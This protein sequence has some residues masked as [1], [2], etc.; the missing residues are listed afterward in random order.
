MTNSMDAIKVRYSGSKELISIRDFFKKG[1]EELTS[2]EQNIQHALRE[3]YKLND[4]NP[5][6]YTDLPTHDPK[7][8]LVMNC[9][10]AHYLSKCSAYYTTG[11]NE[12]CFISKIGDLIA[13][14]AHELKHAEQH[15]DPEIQQICNGSDNRK[16]QEDMLMREAEAFF[17]GAYAYAQ[18]GQNREETPVGFQYYLDVQKKCVRPDGTHD[19]AKMKQEFMTLMVI[20][21]AE[22]QPP[23]PIQREMRYPVTDKDVGLQH[24]PK[25]YKLDD[26]FLT[27][28]KR[29]PRE[30]KTDVGKIRQCI[31]N[32][33]Q[34]LV[35]PI[36]KKIVA[37]GRT[38]S[39]ILS[40]F[41]D[42]S[43]IGYD[44]QMVVHELLQLKGNDL[45]RPLFDKDVIT[46]VLCNSIEKGKQDF[47][48]DLKL[49]QSE[50]DP[51][52]FATASNKYFSFTSEDFDGGRKLLR[53]LGPCSLEQK[54]EMVPF[55]VGFKGNNNAPLIESRALVEYL[56]DLCARKQD[57]KDVETLF[58]SLKDKQGRLPVAHEDFVFGW[59]D[60]SKEGD[61]IIL[62]KIVS[63]LNSSACIPS[64]YEKNKEYYLKILP[65]LIS[66]K[67]KDGKA[68]I[69]Q[70]DIANFPQDNPLASAIKAYKKP[71]GKQK[72]Q[73]FIAS[74]QKT[75]LGNSSTRHVP[76]G[77]N[78]PRS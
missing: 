73:E 21:L 50:I 65:V 13:T 48:D 30:A 64:I 15:A 60:P 34:D 38:K 22:H 6:L 59:N 69:S 57:P 26:S 56:S 4:K 44:R 71:Q 36:I 78:V 67:D 32:N 14:I 12:V 54:K 42:V 7:K 27:V 70:D 24:I 23:Y 55:L 25:H 46:D 43:L 49:F 10:T 62:H 16:K 75:K 51:D 18:T 11:T 76:G 68:I 37:N 39:S 5:R 58:N 3:V 47:V 53:A 2:A 35:V 61:N 1:P 31:A 74:Q 29:I 66:L 77:R 52:A 9:L 17:V 45:G 40:E 19:I 72:L 8:P 41:M 63:M 33:R 28:L 20:S